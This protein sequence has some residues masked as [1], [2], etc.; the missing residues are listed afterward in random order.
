[1]S[2]DLYD[3]I[4]LSGDDL[5]VFVV[6]TLETLPFYKLN[7][8]KNNKNGLSLNI[9]D[10][11][12]EDHYVYKK[13]VYVIYEIKS[14][15]VRCLYI[16]K[17]DRTNNI[18]TRLYRFG[19]GIFDIQKPYEQNHPAAAKARKDGIKSSK[20]LYVRYMTWDDIEN[21]MPNIEKRYKRDIIDEKV[22]K[23]INPKYNERGL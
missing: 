6:K 5:A 12:G 22:A 3:Q 23:I 20:N 21:I 15:K 11:T 18:R 9:K 16:G 4:Y 1:M 17:S 10:E 13:G 19:I 14:K 8:K 2:R 7:I